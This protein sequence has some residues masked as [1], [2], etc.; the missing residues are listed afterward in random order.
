[1]IRRLLVGL[2][3]IV[4]ALAAGIA[5]GGGPLS[6]IGRT[7]S[8]AA[9]APTESADPV[10][11]AR[12]GFADDFAGGV[13]GQ[14]YAGRLAGQ[15]VAIV[16]VPGA[17]AERVE[18]LGVEVAA[19]GGEVTGTYALRRTLLDV[20][21][22]TLV[23]T[24]GIQVVEQLGDDVV[25]P[26]A[27]TYDRAGQLIGRA[28]ASKKPEKA[29]PAA[30]VA[31]LRASLK[32]AGLLGLPEGEPGLASLVLVVTGRE[33]EPLVLNGLASGLAAAA[34]AVV[35][36]GPTADEDIVGLRAEPPARPVTTVDGID[37]PAGRVVTTLALV[38]ALATPG[39]A[40]GASG[41]DGPVPLG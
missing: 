27:T 17:D 31:S 32:G 33:V 22:K 35:V 10:A 38:H 15:T 40:Y 12:G 28:V 21:D 13:A 5:L 24:L 7:P 25:T 1:V 34:A 30:K 2:V 29:L 14:L 4:T 20:S 37:A 11:E 23:D 6:D 9:P 36:A 41:A 3:V 8:Q 39:G 19:A 18:Q 26:D 16:T